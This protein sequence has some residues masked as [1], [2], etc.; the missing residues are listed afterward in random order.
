VAS[1][2]PPSTPDI[3][4]IF[5][6]HFD[7]VWNALR[8][9]G[10]RDGER[11][12]LAHEVFLKVYAR[13]A[14]YDTARP[15]RPWLFGFAYRVAADHLR[16]ARHR[17]EVFGARVEPV[18]PVCLADRRIEMGQ[19]GALVEAALDC[20]DVDR[21]AVLVM[22]EVEELSVP[23]IARTLDIPVNTAYSRLRL[24]REDLAAAVTRLRKRGTW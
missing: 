15:M 22:H 19:D 21:R 23:A 24:A 4:E 20:L 11:E 1:G 2:K 18:D 7:Y 5:D 10:V 16:L 3:G 6:E 17:V 13:L 14:D 8:R 12:D 9:L